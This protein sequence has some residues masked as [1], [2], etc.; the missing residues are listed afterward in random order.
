MRPMPTYHE[1]EAFGDATIALMAGVYRLSGDLEVHAHDF[2]EIAVIGGGSGHHV[3]SQGS[4]PA[5]AG[6][7]FLLRPGAWHG[8]ADCHRLIVA[9][10][11]LGPSALRGDA[12]FLREIPALHDLLWLGPV[13]A[14]HHGVLATRI[15]ERDATEAVREITALQRDLTIRSTNRVL[16]LGRLL[17]VLGNL[18]EGGTDAV[19]GGE[20]HPAVATALARLDE[21]PAHAWQLDEL[22]REVNLDPAYLSRL[23]RRHLGL[24]PIAYLTRI[25]AERAATLLT[26]SSEPIARVGALVGWPDPTYFAR[27]FRSFAGVSPTEYR[28][29]SRSDRRT[30]PSD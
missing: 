17:A 29:R 23:F 30:H 1:R 18:V 21:A 16:L 6:D 13:S 3:S 8:F 5:R 12:A 4:Y 9:N 11:C 24:P 28:R 19:T 15:P 26:R 27:R 7:V 22:A 10:A 20:V 25:R 2:L 14:G